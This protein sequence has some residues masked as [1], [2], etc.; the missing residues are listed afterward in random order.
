MFTGDQAEATVETE[1]QCVLCGQT[2]P[3][4][5][6]AKVG[7]NSPYR[8]R[9]CGPCRSKRMILLRN[10]PDMPRQWPAV[11]TNTR[12]RVGD[13]GRVCTA[14]GVFKRWPDFNRTSSRQH[15]RGHEAQC[16]KCVNVKRKAKEGR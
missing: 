14:C 7:A 13:E 11:R 5:A 4:T 3:I 15:A 2:K 10:N 16:R 9:Q 12:Y 1:R 6:F 8:R